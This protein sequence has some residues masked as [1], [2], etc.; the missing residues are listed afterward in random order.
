MML[1]L[2]LVLALQ[3]AAPA[4]PPP[5]RP[6]RSSHTAAALADST[7]VRHAAPLR[8]Q[9]TPAL[10]ASAYSDA[11]ARDLVMRSRAAR[12]E[13]DSSLVSYDA[14][15]KQRLTLQVALRQ[16]GRPRLFFR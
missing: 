14:T 16:S 9:V 1:A 5:A 6:A 3:V 11:A 2:T 12:L 10:L 15:A 8:I 4:P 7:S 13:Q